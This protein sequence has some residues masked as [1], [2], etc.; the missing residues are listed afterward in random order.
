MSSLLQKLPGPMRRILPLLLSIGVFI[1]LPVYSHAAN[2]EL[3]LD[4]LV[5]EA[6]NKSP[7]I[8]ASQ[9]RATAAGY[10]PQQAKSLPDPMFMFGY[11]NEGFKKLNIGESEDAMGMF[12]VSQMFPFPGKLRLK[13]EMAA[14]DAESQTEMSNAVKLRVIAQIKTLFNELFL[15]HKTLDILKQRS[16]LYSNIEDAAQT[17]YASGTGMQ[18]EVIM[19]QTEKYMILEKEEMQRQR[20]EALQGMLNTA[21]GRPVS[22]MLP[23]PLQPA[24]SFF[25]GSL[26]D[27]VT[28]AYDYSPEVRSKKRMIEGAEA[29][30][31]MARREYFPDFT[32]GAS[33]F[34][35]TKG[36][37]DMWNLTVTF[38]LPIFYMTK[39]RQA[40]YEAQADLSEAMQELSATKLMIS[41]NI[42]DSLSMVDAADRLMRL[43]TE[44]LIPKTNQDVQLAFSSY[45]TGRID[46]LTVIS[47]IK[48]LLDYEVL[49]WNQ[50]A[51]R[52]K[53]IA[54]IHALTGEIRAGTESQAAR[55]AGIGGTR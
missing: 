49:Y 53:A 24:P 12:S 15:A 10:R 42:R 40:V 5:A 16:D 41:S 7:E 36:M 27:L 45:V 44:G 1:M 33:Y 2:G 13:G 8:L 31:K 47:R 9:A 3:N 28:K 25:S 4:E 14:K 55:D 18:Q 20:I 39:Q 51:E 30:I 37:E 52:E 22:A 38:N 17:R 48:N 29:K 21:V 34:P 19:A 35:R 6:L 23:R 54:K 11:Q 43:Y 46:T 26:Q 32:L 50:F